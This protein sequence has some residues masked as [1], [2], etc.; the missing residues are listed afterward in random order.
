[1]RDMGLGGVQYGTVMS[2]RQWRLNFVASWSLRWKVVMRSDGDIS[3]W[4]ACPYTFYCN[5]ATCNC[6]GFARS[7]SLTVAAMQQNEDRVSKRAE[8]SQ[9]GLKFT[10]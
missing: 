6:F 2:F 4:G 1:M 9:N 10:T 3:R 5:N 7:P 8:S